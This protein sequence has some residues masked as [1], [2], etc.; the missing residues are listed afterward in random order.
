[1][2]WGPVRRSCSI[3]TVLPVKSCTGPM[4]GS[5]MLRG[6]AKVA[7][8]NRK[9]FHPQSIWPALARSGSAP[10]SSWFLR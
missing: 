10:L 6:L 2:A 5:R 3:T 8:G 9:R 7:A 1:M 4:S